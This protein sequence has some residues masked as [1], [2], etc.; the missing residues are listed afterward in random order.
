MSW[1]EVLTSERNPSR[2]IALPTLE[3]RPLS[4]ILDWNQANLR[5]LYL[6]QERTG[7]GCP[8]VAMAAIMAYF[9]LPL[10]AHQDYWEGITREYGAFLHQGSLMLQHGSYGKA[11][12]EMYETKGIQIKRITMN[13]NGQTIIGEGP[14]NE[15]SEE[16]KVDDFNEL[17]TAELQ[18]PAV[19]IVKQS[20]CGESHTIA[21][22]NSEVSQK[23]RQVYAQAGFRTVAI[24]EFKKFLGRT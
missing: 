12:R 20:G 14:E 5:E 9:G 19:I 16:V 24:I 10:P 2:V 17:S 15:K 3:I 4:T 23:M 11:M 6:D 21:I 1:Q 13:K 18:A 7:E 8:F 22:D